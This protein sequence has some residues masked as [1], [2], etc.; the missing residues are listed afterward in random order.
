MAFKFENLEV[1]KM[2][3]D[4]AGK[5]HVINPVISKRRDFFTNIPN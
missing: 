3:V 5:A 1:W 4:M 2:A